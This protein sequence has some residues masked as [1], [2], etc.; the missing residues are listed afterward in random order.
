[1]VRRLKAGADVW[2]PNLQMGPGTE[3]LVGVSI[4]IVWRQSQEAEHFSGGS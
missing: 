4:E 2:E 3:S 1:M